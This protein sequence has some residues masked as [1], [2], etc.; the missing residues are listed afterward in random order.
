MKEKTSSKS[1]VIAGMICG[2][3]GYNGTL[4][5]AGYPNGKI[6]G[7]RFNGVEDTEEYYVLKIILMDGTSCQIDTRN[8]AP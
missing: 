8:G 2:I 7:E 4:Y 5:E 1:L 6:Y 3:V